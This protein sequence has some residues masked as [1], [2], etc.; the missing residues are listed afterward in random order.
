MKRLALSPCPDD[1]ASRPPPWRTGRAAVATVAL[2]ERDRHRRGGDFTQI[3]AEG[4]GG[5][6]GGGGSI[7]RPAASTSIAPAGC[8]SEYDGEDS[9]GRRGRRAGW[10]IFDGRS[11]SRPEQY[12][13]RETPLNLI[14]E[15]NVDLG[16][17]GMVIGHEFRRHRDPVS[18]HKDPDRPEDRDDRTWSSPATRSNCANGLITDSTGSKTTVVLWRP[19]RGRAPV[20]AAVSTSR[21][22]SARGRSAT[23]TPLATAQQLHP[24]GLGPR[25]HAVGHAQKPWLGVVAAPRKARVPL[26]DRRDTGCAQSVS[27][28]AV[29]FPRQHQCTSP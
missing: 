18:W 9:A 11:N 27:A 25:R 14:V 3:N 8:A 21:S 2:P 16:R 23:E 1:R 5:G 4:G 10:A 12:P 15:R 6:G 26:R 7:L 17:S 28:T 20:V 19:G 22:R 24:V 29:A 13:L